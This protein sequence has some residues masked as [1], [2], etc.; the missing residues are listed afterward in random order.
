MRDV[1]DVDETAAESEKNCVEEEEKY[2]ESEVLHSH[3]LLVLGQQ[4]GEPSL[5]HDVK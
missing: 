1:G 2:H 3:Q 5:I 4:A